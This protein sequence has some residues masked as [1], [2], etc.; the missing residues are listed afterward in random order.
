MTTRINFVIDE[1]LKT[2]AMK[3]AK[4][5]G[6]SL[7]TVLSQATRAFVEEDMQIG[8]FGPALMEDIRH[9][10]DD[11]KHARIVSHDDLVQELNLAQG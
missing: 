2:A 1:Q 9:S 6:L 8:F 3:K 11:I 4:R 10:R 5:I 7:S